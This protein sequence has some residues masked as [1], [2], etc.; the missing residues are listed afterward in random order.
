MS[1]ARNAADNAGR[2]KGGV[3]R[4]LVR[5]VLWP[6]RRFFDPRFQGVATQIDVKHEHLSL[7]L[8]EL[9]RL[10]QEEAARVRTEASEQLRA[11]RSAI[12]DLRSLVAAGID[13][14]TEATTL[15]GQSLAELLE[16]SD[17]LRHSLSA[18]FRVAEGREYLRRLSD[19]DVADIDDDAARLLNYASGHLGFAAQRRLWLN[20]PVS[21]A[22]RPGRVEVSSV[23][24]RVVEIPYLFRA[25]AHVPP[26]ARILDVGATEST[27]SLSLAS[28]GFRVTAIDP[29]PY[30][31]SHP[32]LET[33]VDAIEDWDYDGAFA[34]L[35]CLSTVEHI[36]L[37]RPS[38]L[39]RA[40]VAA[41]R[42][43]RE[44]TEPGGLL[45]LTVPFGQPRIDGNARRYDDAGL[46]EL[47]EGWDVRDRTI[48]R[49]DDPTT[50]TVATSARP[51][52]GDQNAVAL[53]TAT[54]LA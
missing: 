1:T 46:E 31:F 49:Q 27:V 9:R 45:V 13:S 54:P 14:A 5:A 15:T 28:L 6:V 18:L 21:L 11:A 42:R 40:D 33:V 51:A 25:L 22:Y 41:M 20:A 32:H 36:G 23:N 37:D 43:M 16:H 26:G 35:V 24:E 50:W 8:G 17:D 19:G 38:P 2:G 29:R 4:G 44:L 39:E 10:G 52:A 34:A 12:D 7:Q 3:L 47:L 48:V 30:P 53:V